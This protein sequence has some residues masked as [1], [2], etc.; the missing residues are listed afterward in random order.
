MA[1]LVLKLACPTMLSTPH[2]RALTAI[3]FEQ[4][5]EH[6][7]ETTVYYH[8]QWLQ[9]KMLKVAQTTK[10]RSRSKTST[11]LGH[12]TSSF[13]TKRATNSFGTQSA[14]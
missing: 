7:Y 10:G 6:V 3:P 13:I 8:G 12:S 11:C 5:V 4:D 14:F 9:S 1:T 2:K